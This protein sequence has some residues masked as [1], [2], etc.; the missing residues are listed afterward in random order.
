MKNSK[1]ENGT[2]FVRSI[3]MPN[4]EGDFECEWVAVALEL[5]LWGFGE[6]AEEASRDLN[7]SIESQISFSIAH[8]CPDVLDNQAEKKW[9]DLWDVLNSEAT[10]DDVMGVSGFLKHHQANSNSFNYA[11]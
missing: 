10:S 2:L 6:T 3:V 7:E 4:R 5:N 8:N 1:N 11:A 9:F